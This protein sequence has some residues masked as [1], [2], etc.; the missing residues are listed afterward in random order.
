ME[1]F[2][3][4]Q[5]NGITSGAEKLERLKKRL[6]MHWW[7]KSGVMNEIKKFYRNSDRGPIESLWKQKQTNICAS[8]QYT[9]NGR[10]QTSEYKGNEVVDMKHNGVYFCCTLVK[11]GFP[12][13]S[14]YGQYRVI[15]DIDSVI[16]RDGCMYLLNSYCIGENL[17][18]VLVWAKSSHVFDENTLAS[19][20]V[21][22][23]N[24]P[25]GLFEYDGT[26]WKYRAGTWTEIF[27]IGDVDATV[28]REDIAECRVTG[29]NTMT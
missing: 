17:Y 29:R 1:V 10:K 27:V 19:M 8:F 21:I 9:E 2:K 7:S 20:Q 28:H 5:T 26:N 18:V 3:E 6:A 13:T 12:E 11:E 23:P 22:S 24:E 25:N 14:P 15:V 4:L 16:T